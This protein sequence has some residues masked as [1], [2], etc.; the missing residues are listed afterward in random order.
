NDWLYRPRT[1]EE[2]TPEWGGGVPWRQ[3]P[4]QIDILRTI[5]GGLVQNLRGTVGVWDESRRVAGVYSAYLDFADGAVAT[6]LYSGYDHLSSA[7]L[8]RGLT[9]RGPIVP[10]DRYARA[11][12]EFAGNPEA[13]A[14]AAAAE[15]YGG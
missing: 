6:A 8:M 10:E 7:T 3:G 2:F 15:R 5:G 1:P 13:E 12:K 11:R 14:A 9:N 4:H